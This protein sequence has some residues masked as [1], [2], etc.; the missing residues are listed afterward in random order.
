M[1]C[2]RFTPSFHA[3]S[4]AASVPPSYLPFSSPWS[5]D[6]VTAWST[7][8]WL[9]NPHLEPCLKCPRD[10]PPASWN[11]STAPVP[12]TAC[13]FGYEP[14]A[15]W[16]PPPHRSAMVGFPAPVLW[17]EAG[18]MALFSS[19]SLFPLEALGEGDRLVKTSL[20]AVRR[21]SNCPLNGAPVTAW[22][23]EAGSSSRQCAAPWN[24]A[25]AWELEWSVW[26]QP[27]SSSDFY[28]WS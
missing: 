28:F 18:E 23:P 9:R 26:G 13:Q 21:D 17:K 7:G 20:W 3:P 24:R 5:M 19:E 25:S 2:F 15:R 22:R 16:S 10:P 1:G 27:A 6:F 4:P 12:G 11:G 14:W 8:Y